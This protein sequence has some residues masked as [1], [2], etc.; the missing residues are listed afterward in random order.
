[1]PGNDAM[2]V[3]RWLADK[4]VSLFVKPHPTAIEQQAAFENIQVIDEPW[5]AAHGLT[6][7]QMLAATDVL[8]TDASSV[9][10]DFLLLERPIIYVFPD[11]REYE[12]SRGLNL[13]PYERWVPG[14]IVSNADGLIAVLDGLLQGRDEHHQERV[15]ARERFHRYADGNSTK[16]LLDVL[17]F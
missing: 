15:L 13:A 6:T 17:G 14:P 8:I 1:M 10:V 4:S 16:R 7:Y 2:R 9:W 11:L 12:A 5:L 3:D